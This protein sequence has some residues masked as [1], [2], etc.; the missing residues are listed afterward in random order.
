LGTISFTLVSDD[1]SDLTIGGTTVIN[2]DGIHPATPVTVTADF[3]QNGLYMIDVQYFNQAAVNNG[4][5]AQLML[6]DSRPG[7]LESQLFTSTP[8]PASAA[9]LGLG[10]LILGL[11]GRKSLIRT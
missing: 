5:G 2:N 6:T 4:G 3:S 9:L 8:E 7:T 10:C 1:G 11:V